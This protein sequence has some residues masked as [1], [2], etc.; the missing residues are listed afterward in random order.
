MLS[1]QGIL[2]RICKNL[3]TARKK[4]KKEMALTDDPVRKGLLNGK[5]LALKISCNSVY[6][7]TG[8]V[9]G[10]LPCVAI[11]SSVTAI[12]QQMIKT[13]KTTVEESFNATVIYGDTDSVMVNFHCGDGQEALA[14]ALRMGKVSVVEWY[15]VLF[16]AS[17]SSLV[18]LGMCGWNC[19]GA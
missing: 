5:Q 2:P 4:A 11:A 16:H 15:G 12:G 1:I 7:F 3:L 17:E 13:T 19:I 18:F 8:A 9:R 6:G 10:M 14:E